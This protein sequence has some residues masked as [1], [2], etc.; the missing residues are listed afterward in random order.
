VP[1]GGADPGF[2]THVAQSLPLHRQGDPEDVAAA[3]VY[4]A[5]TTFVTGEV[6]YVDGGR[7]LKECGHGSSTG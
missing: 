1:V 5:G 6:I 2:M 3:V 4:L 7:H